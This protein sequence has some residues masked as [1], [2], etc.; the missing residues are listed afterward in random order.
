MAAGK[1]K[2][3]ADLSLALEP[4][5]RA[6]KMHADCHAD[7]PHVGEG[8]IATRIASPVD[9]GT[10]PAARPV[11]DS[12]IK[13]HHPDDDEYNDEKEEDNDALIGLVSHYVLKMV[14]ANLQLL[15]QM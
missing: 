15:N 6:G 14:Q 12:F 2:E 9:R 3:A 13:L 1:F 4:R 8:S 10:D 5:H 7:Q 11:T